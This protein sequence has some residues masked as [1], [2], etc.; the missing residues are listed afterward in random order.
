MRYSIAI[1]YFKR[2]RKI[3]FSF[4]IIIVE[5]PQSKFWAHCKQN[6][7]FELTPDSKT[8]F[9]VGFGPL[10]IRKPSCN[11]QISDRNSKKI[12][13]PDS[14]VLPF[15]F[16]NFN[17]CYNIKMMSR[18]NLK[19]CVTLNGSPTL[20]ATSEPKRERRAQPR[21]PSKKVNRCEIIYHCFTYFRWPARPPK[22]QVALSVVE[23]L[24]Q[25]NGR[26]RGAER[27]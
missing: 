16:I 24:C 25:P 7:I 11:F 12:W 21:H 13:N 22:R 17:I 19:F 27:P 4:G 2:C 6:G 18:R 15:G 14:P 8:D 26:R 10:K 3:D 20:T 9:R 23:S 1:V 5:N